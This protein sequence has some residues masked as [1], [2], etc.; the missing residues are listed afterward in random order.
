MLHLSQQNFAGISLLGLR[1]ENLGADPSSPYGSGHAYFST[2][3]NAP[4]IYDGAVWRNPFARGDHSGTQTAATISDLPAVVKGYSLDMFA[5]PVADVN[6]NNRRLTG[7]ADPASAQDAATQNYV[8][9]KVHDA[10]AGITS[11][12]PVRAVAT[13]NITLSG[14]QTIDGVVLAAGD[15]VLATAQTTATG[16]GVYTVAAGAWSRRIAED[17]A[18]EMTAG[19][20]WLVTEGTANSGTQWRQATVGNVVLGTTSLSIL[21]FAT[22]GGYTAGNGL[23]LASGQFSVKLPASSGLLVDATGLRL[24]SVGR[25]VKFAVTIGDGSTTAITV[26]H[27]LNTKDITL[28]VQAVSDGSSVFVDWRAATVNTAILTFAAAPAT[29]A[30]RVTVVG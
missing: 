17:E 22:G 3:L 9:A 23:N 13:A 24:D 30:Y 4:R 7:L 18:S 10:A 16:N 2:V 8:L 27:N 12:P 15:S 29:G 26:T 1:L 28:S 20:T 21:Q 14:T 25:L 19:A 5:P 6:Y 11:R